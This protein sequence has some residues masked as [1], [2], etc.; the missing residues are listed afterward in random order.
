MFMCIAAVM[1]L[2]PLTKQLGALM[3]A[4]TKERTQPLRAPQQAPQDSDSAR[5]LALL[6]LAVKRL[7]TME[8]RLDFTERLVS[9]NQRAMPQLSVQ[10][11]SDV[12]FREESLHRVAR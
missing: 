3:E 2:R 11:L 8:D 10:N 7:D 1:I 4:M 6:E 9:S 5:T 12:G